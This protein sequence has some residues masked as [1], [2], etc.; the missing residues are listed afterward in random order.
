MKVAKY[1]VSAIFAMALISPVAHAASMLDHAIRTSFLPEFDSYATVAVRT[2]PDMKYTGSEWIGQSRTIV[3]SYV[4]DLTKGRLYRDEMTATQRRE[5][6]NE[7]RGQIPMLV[8][9][10]KLLIVSKFCAMAALAPAKMQA[11]VAALRNYAITIQYAYVEAN[12]IIPPYSVDITA[13]DV[14]HCVPEQ[15]AGDDPSAH[16]N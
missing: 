3:G 16:R 2:R 7:I 13:A 1:S 8:A 15:L 4:V 9:E 12:N 5:A 14:A 6:R 10:E 11:A